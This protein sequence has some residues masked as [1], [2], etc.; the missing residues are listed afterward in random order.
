MHDSVKEYVQ[1][2]PLNRVCGRDVL[3]VGSRDVNG[4]ITDII[5]E[6]K[7]KN[8]VRTDMTQGE[9]VDI[10]VNAD[11]L[12]E[13]FG[14]GTWNIVISTETLEHIQDW[15]TALEQMKRV[16]KPSGLLV[17]TTRSPGFPQHDY[18][19]DYHR[20]TKD[21]MKEILRDMI[22]LDLTD[23]PQSPGVFVT[24]YKPTCFELK[25]NSMVEV[26]KIGGDK[27]G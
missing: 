12:V 3:E 7:P 27:Y 16:L 10:V 18:P 5:R 9:N 19:E 23:D 1:N 15:R 21:D 14:E 24:A 17:I 4:K 25:D 2:I 13:T 6:M 22:I 20:Y 26:H 8:Y 11:E